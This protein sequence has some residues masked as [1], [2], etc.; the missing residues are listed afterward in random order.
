MAWPLQREQAQ[1]AG[2][3]NSDL[4][5]RAG[6]WGL[7]LEEREQILKHVFEKTTSTFV[8]TVQ[9]QE[10][11]EPVRKEVNADGDTLLGDIEMGTLV[12]EE[13][14]EKRDEEEKN[15]DETE[16][17]TEEKSG[18]R[19]ETEETGVQTDSDNSEEKDETDGAICPIC[20]VPY[21]PDQT[22]MHG[23]KCQHV[24]HESCCM[25]WLLDQRK[26]HCPTCRKQVMSVA[27]FRQA[28]VDVLGE[29]RVRELSLPPQY[30][31]QQQGP[32]TEQNE[33]QQQREEE[34]LSQRD[35]EEA[36]A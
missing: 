34:E 15:A 29:D 8:A 32:T 18:D 26:D 23:T 5:G 12:V 13:E 24:F 6:L 9:P 17:L 11:T 1:T 7:T 36:E 27:E 2:S 30:L 21:Q 3:G 31:Q 22:V 14:T 33:E 20:L 35:E 28:A 4:A 25:E 19:N 16:V 10:Q